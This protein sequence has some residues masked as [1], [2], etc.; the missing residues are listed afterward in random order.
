MFQTKRGVLPSEVSC[1][2]A[3]VS[4]DLVT[5]RSAV[6]T[7]LRVCACQCALVK[8]R[9]I[10]I[11]FTYYIYPRSARCVL[12]RHRKYTH[13]RPR[14]V[15]H[16]LFS[17]TGSN[18]KSNECKVAVF[19]HSYLSN[20]HL[21]PAQRHRIHFYQPNV[22]VLLICC[23]H[24]S[25]WTLIGN[26]IFNKPEYNELNNNRNNLLGY[27]FQGKGNN[28]ASNKSRNNQFCM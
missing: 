6:E 3:S 17:C 27:I 12:S 15:L 13:K 26:L 10:Q 4:D 28:V 9:R 16:I 11:H 22:F 2:A 5:A 18:K 7:L 23:L 1:E 20:E 19:S 21:F 25:S 24:P 14:K 8:F